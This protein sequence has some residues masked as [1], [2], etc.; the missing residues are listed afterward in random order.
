MSQPLLEC[1]GEFVMM[2]P[3]VDLLGEDGPNRIAGH[4][5]HTPEV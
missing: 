4:N 2:D 1:A 5:I 3:N